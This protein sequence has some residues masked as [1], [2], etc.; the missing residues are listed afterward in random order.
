MF[1]Y[2][3]Y[4][5]VRDSVKFDALCEAIE[6]HGWQGAPLVADGEC[7]LT[8]SHRYAAC[9][10]VEVKPEVV[11]IRDI[12]P[13]WEEVIADWGNPTWGEGMYAQAVMSLPEGILEQYGIE[14]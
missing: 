9:K 3:P 11:D 8:G 12:Y 4:H 2:E 6:Q 14:M 7:L 10:A 1:G 13:E 5:E